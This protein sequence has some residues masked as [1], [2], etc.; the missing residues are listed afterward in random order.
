[1]VLSSGTKMDDFGQPPAWFDLMLTLRRCC[2]KELVTV[3]LGNLQWDFLL[4][5]QLCPMLTSFC[6]VWWC[7]IFLEG[8]LWQK[9]SVQ[10]RRCARHLIR[11]WEL[12]MPLKDMFE[13]KRIFVTSPP[14]VTAFPHTRKW[15]KS[16]PFIL[17][18]LCSCSS[19]FLERLFSTPPMLPP[20]RKHPPKHLDG[21]LW[22]LYASF[23]TFFPLN[24]PYGSSSNSQEELIFLPFFFF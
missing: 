9:A 19:H 22:I 11:C 6:E 1:M 5:P 14:L 24:L 18:F 16:Y 8:P 2:L 17:P 3:L 20:K 10:A 7:E 23:E 21:K 15:N 4:L 12:K 13:Q